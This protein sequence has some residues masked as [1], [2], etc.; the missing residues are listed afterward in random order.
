MNSYSVTDK[1]GTTC[2]YKIGTK[3][4]HREGDLPAVECASSIYFLKLQLFCQRVC[5]ALFVS[6]F[7]STSMSLVL[8]ECF[9]PVRD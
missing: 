8:V 6:T 3:D 9:H 4:L 7:Y 5:S 1:V 2:W